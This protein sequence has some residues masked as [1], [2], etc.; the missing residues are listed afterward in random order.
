MF[1]PLVDDLSVL[2]DL[3]I[4]NKISELSRKYF[5]AR[6]PELQ[7]QVAVILEMYKQESIT[8]REKARLQQNQENGEEG[9]DNL[10]NIS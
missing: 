4:E 1:N 9:L 6:N 5:Q 10:I 3:E 8:R 2:D 7:R